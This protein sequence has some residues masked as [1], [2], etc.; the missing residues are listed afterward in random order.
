MRRES[1]SGICVT[2][3]WGETLATGPVLWTYPRAMR[4]RVAPMAVVGVL[5]SLLSGVGNARAAPAET[6]ACPY[7]NP[8]P[9]ADLRVSELRAH[10]MS[11]ASAFEV[12][13]GYQRSLWQV[14]LGGHPPAF[15][16][17]VL[18]AGR[19]WLC[20]VTRVAADHYDV[21]CSPGSEYGDTTDRTTAALFWFRPVLPRDS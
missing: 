17:P 10:G 1:P 2:G 5:V 12:V 9:Y 16:A 11:C 18:L 15:T 7:V 14:W 4:A 19:W 3:D 21:G 13:R 6:A 20:A 8:A